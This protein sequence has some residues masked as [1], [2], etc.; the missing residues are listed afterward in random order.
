MSV[1][2]EPRGKAREYAALSCNIYRGCGHGCT[3]CYAPSATFTDRHKFFSSPSIRTDI[4]KHVKKEASTLKTNDPVLLCFTCDAY[5]PLDVETG[6]TREVLRVFDFHKIPCQ[7]LT[8]GGMRASRDFDILCKD[9]R[10]LFSVTLTHDDPTVSLE[11][12]PGAALPEDRIES[13]KTAKQH[14]ISTWVSFEPVFDP[15]AVYRLIEKT[16][17]WVDLY[18]VGKLNYHKAA[19]GIN[20]RGFREKTIALLEKHGKAYYIKDDLKKAV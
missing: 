19:K 3:Y 14:D 10:N 20:W 9:N 12:E 11:W 2:Y 1:I 17:S 15:E 18:K 7:V 4:L 16:H 13:L 6:L 5:Q 8:K